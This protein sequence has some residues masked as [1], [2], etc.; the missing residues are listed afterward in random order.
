MTIARLHWHA[1]WHQITII[2]FKQFPSRIEGVID[3]LCRYTI[4]KCHNLSFSSNIVQEK[5]FPQSCTLN[6][7][8]MKLYDINVK[9]QRFDKFLLIF[10]ILYIRYRYRLYIKTFTQIKHYFYY[11]CVSLVCKVMEKKFLCSPF[12]SQS[13]NKWKW[14]SF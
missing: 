13:K 9:L 1:I 11:Y 14:K 2:R 5:I 8:T 3:L 12:L 7:Y 10:T 4:N 6:Y